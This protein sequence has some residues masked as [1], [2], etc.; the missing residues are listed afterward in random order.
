MKYEEEIK[1]IREMMD[2]LSNTDAYA[3]K[4]NAEELSDG[5]TYLYTK[6]TG[7][8]KDIIVDSAE[9]YKYFRFIRNLE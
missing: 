5:V 9:T 4:I 6:D 3:R 8:S 7:L 2:S 1:E